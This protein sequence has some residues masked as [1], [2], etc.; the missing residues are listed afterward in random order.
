MA[1]RFRKSMS[2]LPILAL[3]DCDKFQSVGLSD[4]FELIF[5][6]K[7]VS[8]S[9]RA[10]IVHD[11][12]NWACGDAGLASSLT[13]CSC[14]PHP[15][16]SILLLVKPASLSRGDLDLGNNHFPSITLRIAWA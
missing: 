9:Y 2:V 8:D 1:M 16:S 4:P 12:L 7:R 10:R 11:Q 14:G 6:K 13:G 3:L 5:W 15:G